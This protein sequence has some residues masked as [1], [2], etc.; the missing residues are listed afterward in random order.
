MAEVL[1]E[2]RSHLVE[3]VVL[4]NPA[5]L[6]GDVDGGQDRDPPCRFDVM[7]AQQCVGK[8]RPQGIADWIDLGLRLGRGNRDLAVTRRDQDT[9]PGDNCDHDFCLEYRVVGRLAVA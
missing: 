8:T 9:L 6:L 4:L 7:T 2:T 3:S 5:R 1:L